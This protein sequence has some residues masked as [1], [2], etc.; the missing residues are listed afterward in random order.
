MGLAAFCQILPQ[1]AG[2]TGAHTHRAQGV[3]LMHTLVSALTCVCECG[4]CTHM[5]VCTC[6]HLSVHL[7]MRC[8]GACMYARVQAHMCVCWEAGT[9]MT[10]HPNRAP[11]PSPALKRGGSPG[12]PCWRVSSCSPRG[13]LQSQVSPQD[14]LLQNHSLQLLRAHPPPQPIVIPHKSK[15]REKKGTKL[16]QVCNGCSSNKLMYDTEETEALPETCW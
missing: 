1:R 13:H 6:A 7:W 12:H 14:S 16:P 8:P 15:N 3:A 10:A 2:C 9:M 4:V 11:P 5:L